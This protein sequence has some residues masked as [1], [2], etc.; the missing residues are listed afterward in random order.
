LTSLPKALVYQILAVDR[1]VHADIN[2]AQLSGQ[3]IGKHL[4]FDDTD[5]GGGELPLDERYE[6]LRVLG[7][8]RHGCYAILQRT[9]RRRATGHVACGGVRG[10]LN[11]ASELRC[12]SFQVRHACCSVL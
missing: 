10:A 1:R 12:M 8:L 2:L 7:A 11:S 4:R 6:G 9:Q 3:A 5:T